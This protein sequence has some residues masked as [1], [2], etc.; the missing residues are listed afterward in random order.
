MSGR[1]RR[2]AGGGPH[3]VG[4]APPGGGG[5]PCVWVWGG[6]WER[7]GAPAAE[8]CAGAV[9][10]GRAGPTCWGGTR[11]RVCRSAFEGLGV[12]DFDVDH[13]TG[14]CLEGEGVAGFVA[15]D[16]GTEGRLCGEHLDTQVAACVARAE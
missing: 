14:G 8:V 7:A 16:G 1:C 11:P 6:V 3:G 10:D 4:G 2:S 9:D 13:A 15:D 5:G 12:D